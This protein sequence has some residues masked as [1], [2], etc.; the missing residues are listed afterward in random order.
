M[1][2]LELWYEI[3]YSDWGAIFRAVIGALYLAAVAF[4]MFQCAGVAS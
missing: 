2:W 3:R 1:N 4:L